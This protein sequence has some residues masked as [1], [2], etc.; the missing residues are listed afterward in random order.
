MPAPLPRSAVPPP[1][2]PPTLRSAARALRA[3]AAVLCLAGATRALVAQPAAPAAPTHYIVGVDLSASR[4]PTQLEEARRLLGAL[5]A[6]LGYGDRLTLVETYQAG[7][8]AARQWS[9]SAPAVRTPGRVTHVDEKHLARF[10]AAAGGVAAR[11]IDPVRSKTI[12]S[13]DL[14]GTLQRAADYARAGNGRRTTVLLL[15]DMLNSTPE[16]NMEPARWS[17]DPRW[18]VTRRAERQLPS[19]GGVCVV[20]A[21]ADVNSTRG[22]RVRGFWQAY[23]QATGTQLPPERYRAFVADAAEV[24]C[25]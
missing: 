14:L 7:T 11:F 24:R 4:T 13:T 1:M 21:G 18:L 20:V 23:F 15:S 17:P 25:T 8:G 6:R 9:D 12:R 3:T 10:R 22:V 19:L 16:L 5:V 2:L